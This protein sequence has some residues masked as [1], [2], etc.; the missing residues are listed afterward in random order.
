VAIDLVVLHSISL[1]PGEYGGDG[2]VRLFTNTLDW[3]AHPYYEASAA[4]RSRPTS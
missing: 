4:W 1:P 2:I 3:S